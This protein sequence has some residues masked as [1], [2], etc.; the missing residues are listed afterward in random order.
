[1]A[2]FRK[3]KRENWFL[4]RHVAYFSQFIFGGPESQIKKGQAMVRLS[5]FLRDPLKLKQAVTPAM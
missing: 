4:D 2:S 3:V 1:V 5:A